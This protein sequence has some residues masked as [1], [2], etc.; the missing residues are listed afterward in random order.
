M[1]HQSAFFALSSTRTL[2]PSRIAWR[3]PTRAVLSFASAPLLWAGV[4]PVV[5][6]N[7]LVL[8]SFASAGAAAY[9]LVRSL[10]ASQPGAWFAGVVFA[11][12]PY[13]FAHYPQL[14]LLWSCWIPLAFWAL[15]RA[16]E[17]RRV[18][19]G[20][21]LGLFV[22]LQALSCLYYALFLVLALAIVAPI[23]AIAALRSAALSERQRVDRRRLR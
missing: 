21:W 22:A 16:I 12:Q 10:G 23:D 11:F 2:I 14:E 13:R 6:Y 17:T 1:A 4:S 8:A 15:H 3:T 19:Y 7:L 9:F 18:R 20:V 5:A